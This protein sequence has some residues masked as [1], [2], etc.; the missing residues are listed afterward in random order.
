MGKAVGSPRGEG[1]GLVMLTGDRP[2]TAIA[3]VSLPARNAA[4]AKLVILPR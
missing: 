4:A 3:A 2:A 1:L